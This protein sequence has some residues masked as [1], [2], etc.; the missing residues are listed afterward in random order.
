MK[1]KNIIIVTVSL[2]LAGGATGWYF[3]LYKPKKENQRKTEICENI[4]VPAFI[5]AFGKLDDV[6]QSCRSSQLQKLYAENKRR[7]GLDGATMEDHQKVEAICECAVKSMLKS[8]AGKWVEECRGDNR[9]WIQEPLQL[10]NRFSKEPEIKDVL[11]E[12]SYETC[13]MIYNRR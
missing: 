3:G 2:A 13:E 9:Q 5:N 6:Y 4:A 1:K 12:S 11:I 10:K 8:I 7:D